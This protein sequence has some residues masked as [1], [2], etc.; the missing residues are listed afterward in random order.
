MGW[1]G[2][3]VFEGCG[4]E[5]SLDKYKK[6]IFCEK[7]KI[8]VFDQKHQKRLNKHP[9]ELIWGIFDFFLFRILQIGVDGGVQEGTLGKNEE[10]KRLFA[11]K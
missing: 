6:S 4:F 11:K 7:M 9:T 10:K 5:G 3:R 1:A 2:G 8:L